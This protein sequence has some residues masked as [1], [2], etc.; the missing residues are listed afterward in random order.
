MAIRVAESK[1]RKNQ[2]AIA[3]GRTVRHVSIGE[4][5]ELASKL[6]SVAWLLMA[7]RCARAEHAMKQRVRR[8]NVAREC[9]A[10]RRRKQ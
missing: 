8:L 1:H 3:F 7:I 9:L 4:A 6:T 10:R 2:I 5:Y